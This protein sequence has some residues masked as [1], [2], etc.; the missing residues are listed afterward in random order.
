MLSVLYLFVVH[1]MIMY[2]FDACFVKMR[3][4]L[5]VVTLYKYLFKDLL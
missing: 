5:V 4:S 2:R 3:S 1:I